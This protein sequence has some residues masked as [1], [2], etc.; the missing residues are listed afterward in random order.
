MSFDMLS[1]FSGLWW[2]LV[3]KHPQTASMQALVMLCIVTHLI[4]SVDIHILQ[5]LINVYVIIA[6][7]S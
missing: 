1:S 5:I 2:A 6:L 4:H 3:S 7:M